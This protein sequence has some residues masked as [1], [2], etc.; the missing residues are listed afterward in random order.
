MY[1]LVPIPSPTSFS[2]SPLPI[3]CFLFLFPKTSECIRRW[4]EYLCIPSVSFA[5]LFHIIMLMFVCSPRRPSPAAHNVHCYCS[6]YC[7]VYFSRGRASF[8]YFTSIIIYFSACCSLPFPILPWRRVESGASLLHKPN[9]VCNTL[10]RQ[11]TA[12]ERTVPNGPAVYPFR[13]MTD[14][15]YVSSTSSSSSSSSS[16]SP[17]TFHPLLTNPRVH[18]IKSMPAS[19]KIFINEHY[20]EISQLPASQGCKRSKSKRFRERKLMQDEGGGGDDEDEQG[21]TLTSGADLKM[22]KLLLTFS[23]SAIP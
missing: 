19:N 15:L 21:Y 10:T 1:S 20:E 9:S 17:N 22:C 3:L 11:T 14:W 13:G 4:R 2:R 6:S 23:H 7:P 8:S 18:Y 5:I 12:R 16:S